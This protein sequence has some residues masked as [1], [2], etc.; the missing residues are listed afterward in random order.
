MYHLISCE[1]VLIDLKHGNILKICQ[2]LQTVN[3]NIVAHKYLDISSITQLEKDTVLVCYD[4]KYILLLITL[5][6]SIINKSNGYS[7]TL[8]VMF[9]IVECVKVV[10]RTGRLK[11]SSKQASQLFFHFPIQALGE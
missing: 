2:F 5:I 1:L 7:L 10:S 6:L 11:S 4:S 9:Y 8:L 3:V